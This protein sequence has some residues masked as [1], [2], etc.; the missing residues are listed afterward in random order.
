MLFCH[1][2]QIAK[3][4][5]TLCSFRLETRDSTEKTYRRNLVSR[6]LFLSKAVFIS[7]I[8]VT[9]LKAAWS[10]IVVRFLWI[11]ITAQIETLI[12]V[13]KSPKGVKFISKVQ[14]RRSNGDIVEF[15]LCGMVTD[16]SCSEESERISG[17]LTSSPLALIGSI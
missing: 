12:K 16:G 17:Y 1:Q 10:H 9:S 7:A 11:E 2:S 8:L 14:H 15:T 13:E 5:E 3:G 4:L 6:D